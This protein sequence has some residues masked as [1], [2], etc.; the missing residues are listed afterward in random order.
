M[1]LGVVFIDGLI[2][3]RLTDYLWVGFVDCVLSE[4][5]IL[6]VAR[7]F[8]ALKSGL[9]NLKSY[10]ESIELP[11]DFPAESRYFP[12]ITAYSV[13]NELVHFKYVG[14][15]EDSP[16]CTTLR[17]RT[18]T[19]PP[20]DIVVK[21]VNRYG[22]KA[23][24]L[25]ADN[26]LAPELLY[27][28]SPGLNDEQPSYASLSMVVME[29]IEGQTLGESRLN[30]ETVESVRRTLEAA[31]ELL[32]GNGLVFGDVRSPNVIITPAKGV[33]LIDF[34]WAGEE[35][36]AKYP[37]LISSVFPWPP[38]VQPL[39]IIERDHDLQMLEKIFLEPVPFILHS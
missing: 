15:L 19:T 32:H 3:Q 2:V 25:L 24:R 16:D 9:D 8:Y 33:K 39:A 27:C 6:R 30:K 17:A 7:F 38:G 11:S 35:G 13:G 14:F 28:G 22:E 26:G 29:F 4:T 1:V 5:H 20:L 18:L 31:L 36:Q 37:Y 21:F 23:H 10:Y 12:S 34:D